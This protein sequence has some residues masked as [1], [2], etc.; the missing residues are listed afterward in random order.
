M[1][2]FAN[3]ILSIALIPTFL[4]SEYAAGEAAERGAPWQCHIIDQSSRGADGV[5]LFDADGDGLLDITTGWEEGGITRIYRN[6][7]PAQVKKLWPAATLGKTRQVEDAAWIDLDR[8]HVRKAV[9]SC[10][11]GKTRAIYVHWP[12]AEKPFE[13]SWKQEVLPASKDRMMWMFAVPAKIGLDSRGGEEL[14]AA[15]KGPG[16]EI[17]WFM[18][19]SD[20]RD[21]SK[22]EWITLSQAGWIM[23]L[24]AI[25][26]D[27]DGDQDLLTT[28]RKGK[29]RGC[30]WLENPGGPIAIM[31][32]PWKNHW[33][34]GQDREVMFAHLADLD[35][36]GLQDILVVTR[37]PDEVLWFR[38]LDA[39]GQKW[40]KQVIPFPGNTGGGKGVAAGDLDGDG[41]LD[42]VLSCEHA[43][44]P[45][46]GVVWMR[47]A[48]DGNQ[49]R[50]EPQEI[51]GPRGIK[52]D[53]IELLDL[54][55]DGDLDV[56][57]CEERD[58]KK[59]LG[60]FWYE[61][62]LK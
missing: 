42:L 26:M 24:F 14:V 43:E 56:L 55:A 58:Q 30:R 7:G 54:D 13:N 61:N 27:G 23:S 59:G 28:D 18:P 39:S 62:P 1:R 35:Q 37:A 25:D 19:K 11:E 36:D 50:W 45:K 51:S 15:G 5:K 10:C 4:S 32:K 31:G 46:S 21:L 22:Y 49:F 41:L 9:V 57:S 38:R 34:G 44:P 40:E 12:P 29:L 20:T 6:P 60:V 16:A 52:Y 2:T 3:T 33:V 17:G 8:Q 47:G 48:R 53:R